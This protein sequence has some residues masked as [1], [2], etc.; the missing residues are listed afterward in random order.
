[1]G[2]SRHRLFVCV[3][4]YTCVR[5]RSLAVNR[6]VCVRLLLFLRN[7]KKCISDEPSITEPGTPD[8]DPGIHS[9]RNERQ[10]KF[11]TMPTISHWSN[12]RRE[13]VD[14]PALDTLKTQLE[15]GLDR[16]V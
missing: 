16:L 13:V 6:H 4:C 2:V 15:R 1:M 11:L 7:T 8:P 14:S 10:N 9:H 5:D 3:Y 12:L